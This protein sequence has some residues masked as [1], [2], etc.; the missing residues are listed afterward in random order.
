MGFRTIHHVES[1]RVH[2][3][4]LS[5]K[6]LILLLSTA[7]RQSSSS[8]KNCMSMKA[9]A[10]QAPSQFAPVIFSQGLIFSINRWKD[11][12][13][14][15]TIF[16]FTAVQEWG[17]NNWRTLNVTAAV[18]IHYYF[19]AILEI[20]V[21]PWKVTGRINSNNG[22]IRSSFS[23]S[24][25]CAILRSCYYCLKVTLGKLKKRGETDF[26]T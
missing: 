11:N 4:E 1:Y 5:D 18:S 17:A 15:I 25:H 26:C 22:D 7:Q 16:H 3:N 6:W 9:N 8:P 23:T 19:S 24:F 20:A 21:R 13:Y 2:V 10:F 14:T 12:P